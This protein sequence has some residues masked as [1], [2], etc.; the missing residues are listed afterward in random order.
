MRQTLTKPKE[1]Y[2]QKYMNYFVSEVEQRDGLSFKK[3]ERIEANGGDQTEIVLVSANG[4]KY[5]L[6]VSDAGV[7]STT[8]TV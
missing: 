7:L 5:K 4:T 1:E 6:Q 8:T 3:G 2:D